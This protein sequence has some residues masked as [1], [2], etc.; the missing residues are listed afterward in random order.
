MLSESVG[1]QTM[2]VLDILIPLQIPWGRDSQ[3]CRKVCFC[4]PR[5]FI[6]VYRRF[7]AFRAPFKFVARAP[8]GGSA[9]GKKGVRRSAPAA[10]AR[11]PP[12]GTCI[13]GPRENKGAGS[14]RMEGALTRAV[15]A[16]KLEILKLTLLNLQ[17]VPLICRIDEM[18]RPRR[19]LLLKAN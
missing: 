10:T 13:N 8:V 2:E 15:N 4:A 9:A 5:F 6:R 7:A 19:T 14:S 17:I 18:A 12:P 16:R 1:I 3:A 11:G